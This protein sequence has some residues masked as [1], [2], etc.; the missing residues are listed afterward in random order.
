VELRPRPCRRPR[1][2]AAGANPPRALRP[3][4]CPPHRRGDGSGR[5]RPHRRPVRQEHLPPIAGRPSPSQVGGD[6]LPHIDRQGQPVTPGSLPAHH[7]FTRPPIDVVQSQ[8]GHFPSAQAQPQQQH[9]DRVVAAPDRA[10]PVAAVQDR[11]GVGLGDPQRQRRAS[12]P[13][14]RQRRPGQIGRHLPLHEAE[15][16]ER[17]QPG[18]EVLCRAHRDRRGLIQHRPSHVRGRHT[19]QALRCQP[20]QETACMV[21][22]A[23]GRARRQSTLGQ[24]VPLERFQQRI[25]RRV[26]H[27]LFGAQDAK[28]A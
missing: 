23:A 12:P 18:D 13:G 2:A 8:P 5:D 3:A 15:A 4:T 11:P 26:G 21:H 25:S 7:E 24:Q 20:G 22:V 28:P 16:Q 1:C 10:A 6:R 14:Q 19:A 17:P 9:D 27:R